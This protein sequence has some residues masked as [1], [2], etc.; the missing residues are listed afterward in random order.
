LEEKITSTNDLA[1]IYNR[2][3]FEQMKQKIRELPR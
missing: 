1:L 3:K 2:S